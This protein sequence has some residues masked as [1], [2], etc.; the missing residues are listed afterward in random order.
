MTSEIEKLKLLRQKFFVFFLGQK[1]TWNGTKK[2]TFGI[3]R[4]EIKFS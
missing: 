2:Q 1:M 3:K 4:I